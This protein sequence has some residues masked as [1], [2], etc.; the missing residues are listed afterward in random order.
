MT[1]GMRFG[2]VARYQLSA[3]AIV[4]GIFDFVVEIVSAFRNRVDVMMMVHA[5]NE[6]FVIKF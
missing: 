6:K 4:I 2:G 5:R 3:I 1:T